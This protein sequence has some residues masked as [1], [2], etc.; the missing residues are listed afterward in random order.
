MGLDVIGDVH[1]QADKLVGLLHRLGYSDSSGVWRHPDRRAVFIGDLVDRGP[2]QVRTVR[3]VREMVDAGAAH[4]VMGNHE[5]NAIAF[6]TPHPGR[7]GDTLRTRLN[8]RGEENLWQHR[9]FLGEV[10]DGSELHVELVEWFRTI[11]LWLELDGARFVHACWD[12]N[13]MSVLEA[14]LGPNRTVPHELMVTSSTKGH[15]HYAALENLI[16]GPEVDLPDGRAYLDKEGIER[17]RARFAWWNPGA[18]TYA[19]GAVIPPNAVDGFGR[20]FDPFGD[21]LIPQ[22][23]AS[24]YRD[25]EPLFFGHYWSTEDNLIHTH[26][27]MCVDL[28][29][30]K[31]GPLAAYRWDGEALIDLTK[32]VT[33]N[34]P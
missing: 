9:A 25:V 13:S 5:F 26:N 12:A 21:E 34:T 14:H 3:L 11:P 4:I 15:P 28:S 2:T 27:A 17:R 32:L 10:V 29:A 6:A 18:T 33:Y 30:G 7:P 8:Q 16:K 19:K 22:L 23:P 31:H 24:P 1:G 20:P